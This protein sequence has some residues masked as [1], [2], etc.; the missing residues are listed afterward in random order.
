MQK[1]YGVQKDGVLGG[2]R[3]GDGGMARGEATT[4]RMQIPKSGICDSS[5]CDESAVERAASHKHATMSWRCG[6]QWVSAVL[7]S[8]LRAWYVM[9]AEDCECSID[10][11]YATPFSFKYVEVDTSDVPHIIGLGGRIIRQ[12][13]TICG[14]FLPLTDFIE[15]LHKILITGRR[16]AC[17]FAEFAM[18]C[19]ALDI[20]QP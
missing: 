10:D 7:R 8:R 15:G 19:C 13:E 20:T 9:V 18:E 12:L 1:P 3:G 6:F 16:P 14:V 2:V 17:F 5:I 4:S 11:L